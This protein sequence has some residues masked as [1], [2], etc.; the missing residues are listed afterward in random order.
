MDSLGDMSKLDSE[1]AAVQY[2]K[3]AFFRPSSFLDKRELYSVS[4]ALRRQLGECPEVVTT[5]VRGAVIVCLSELRD[6]NSPWHE[7]THDGTP[8]ATDFFTFIDNDRI[9]DAS[10]RGAVFDILSSVLQDVGTPSTPKDAEI[11][12]RCERTIFALLANDEAS[13]AYTDRTKETYS[14]GYWKSKD[15]MDAIFGIERFYGVTAAFQFVVEQTATRDSIYE[16]AITVN[17]SPFKEDWRALLT[18]KSDNV[19]QNESLLRRAIEAGL[20]DELDAAALSNLA[21]IE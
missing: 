18:K 21:E 9:V 11:Y 7:Q 20:A 10:N 8:H 4:S 19:D 17:A 16:I 14:I 6:R 3:N 15:F 12:D 13:R 5:F 2:L 1:Q